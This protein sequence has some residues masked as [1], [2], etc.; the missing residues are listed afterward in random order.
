MKVLCWFLFGPF[1]DKNWSKNFKKIHSPTYG[2]RVTLIVPACQLGWKELENLRGNLRG[3][4][5]HE[6]SMGGSLT[7]NATLET[8]LF[9]DMKNF[10]DLKSQHI[11][12]L[13][14]SLNV[15]IVECTF[16]EICGE[17]SGWI[18]W[19]VHILLNSCVQSWC[20]ASIHPFYFPSFT[21]IHKV[22]IK[23]HPLS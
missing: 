10:R 22:L 5:S 3:Y 4:D 14:F 20:Y 8:T 16:Q 23:E 19:K 2:T 9:A 7:F 21:N 13:T 6:V 17:N 15:K 18:L 12:P 1:P 11:S